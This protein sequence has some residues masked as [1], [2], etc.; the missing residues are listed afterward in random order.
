MGLLSRILL[1]SLLGPLYLPL[2]A[3][4]VTVSYSLQL[5]R[6]LQSAGCSL[7]GLE[8]QCMGNFFG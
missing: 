6:Y 4:W 8:S 2:W 1:I 5:V 3:A 7:E